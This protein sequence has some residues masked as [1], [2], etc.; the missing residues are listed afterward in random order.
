MSRDL[1]TDS[2]GSHLSVFRSH[3]CIQP[4]LLSRDTANF[5]CLRTGALPMGLRLTVTSRGSRGRGRG[6]EMGGGG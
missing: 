3:W 2:A 1:T 4:M 6:M 5:F